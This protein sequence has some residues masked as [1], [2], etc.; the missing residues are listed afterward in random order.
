MYFAP[1]Q[2]EQLELQNDRTSDARQL[3]RWF[4]FGAPSYRRRVRAWGWR[5]VLLPR[6]GASDA[7]FVMFGPHGLGV[8]PFKT[9]AMH[10]AAAM[11]LSET[12]EPATMS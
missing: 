5:L 9:S 4:L 2:L 12:E 6:H 7:P 3:V 8:D 11:T 1:E 10:D